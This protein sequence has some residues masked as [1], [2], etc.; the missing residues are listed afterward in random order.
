MAT[1]KG[2]GGGSGSIPPPRK[3][4]KPAESGSFVFNGSVG[5]GS[6]TSTSA[7][8]QGIAVAREQIGLGKKTGLRNIAQALAGI[9]NEFA[10]GTRDIE[11]GRE[12]GT[13]FHE[14]QLRKI[15][16]SRKNA[17]F[18][19]DSGLRRIQ[20]SI[21]DRDRERKTGLRNIEEEER[22][23]IRAVGR[24]A[25]KQTDRVTDA[26]EARGLSRSGIQTE[27]VQEVAAD[28]A[29]DVADIAQDAQEST[30]DL[31][32]SIDSLLLALEG[33]EADL[34]T[35]VGDLLT[36]L[37]GDE[38]AAN[39]EFKL[40]LEGFQN[41]ESDL[42]RDT[43]LGKIDA[44]ADKDELLEEVRLALKALDARKAAGVGGGGLTAAGIANALARA[45]GLTDEF[46]G[47]RP[48]PRQ[49]VTSAD[50]AV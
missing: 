21:A 42:D 18:Q 27:D 26:A 36:A 31:N 32:A 28:A 24:F 17:R 6:G 4:T 5:G 14:D 13:A 48:P 29:E 33:D 46:G 9:K 49:T 2:G 43:T 45:L 47:Q 1:L 11:L 10:S 3:R 25:E 50:R 22:E 7:F 15:E 40:V 16:E 30:F 19:L 23:G 20:E 37:E 34:R 41:L 35:T 12:R 39:A 44:A 38:S 8:N